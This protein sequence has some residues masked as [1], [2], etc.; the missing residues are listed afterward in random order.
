[1]GFSKKD[2]KHFIVVL[3]NNKIS[4][5]YSKNAFESAKKFN[6]DLKIFDAVDGNRESLSDYNL[7]TNIISKK[8]SSAFSRPGVVG[9]FLSHYKLWLKCL[10]LNESIGIFEHDII[11]QKPFSINIKFN[12]LLR[13]DKLSKGKEHGTGDWWEGSHAYLITP[14]GSKKLIDWVT[15]NGAW[16]SDVILGTKILKIEFNNDNLISLD[17]SSKNYSLTK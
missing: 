7:K 15:K 11:F 3:K 10:E 2:M 14:T 9:C 8:S 4:E 6:W 13:L 12:E 5:F 17:K 1:M 16:P